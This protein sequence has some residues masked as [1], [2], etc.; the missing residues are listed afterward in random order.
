M[1]G[2]VTDGLELQVE[3]KLFAEGRSFDANGTVD[4]RFPAEIV[5]PQNNVSALNLKYKM[6]DT[7]DMLDG[8]ICYIPVYEAEI[9]WNNK[10]LR[11]YVHSIGEENILIGVGLLFLLDLDAYIAPGSEFVLKEHENQ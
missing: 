8:T 10:R 5:I 4:T 7:F 1:N 11:V 3:F 2:I 6:L 9:E